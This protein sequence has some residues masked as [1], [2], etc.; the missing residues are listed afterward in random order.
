MSGITNLT[1]LLA[2][3]SP[4]LLP[5]R[6]VFVTVTDPGLIASL[7]PVGIFRENEGTTAICLVE[8]ADRA[9]LP[10]AGCYRQITM[11]VHSSL[12][13]VGFRADALDDAVGR[14]LEEIAPGN[15]R[16]VDKDGL[17]AILSGALLGVRPS[18]VGAGAA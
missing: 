17:R 9:G 18:P 12:E 14:V 8:Q 13:A 2:T 5:G 1:R 4:L 16:V 6:F 15:P 10:H 7:D 11:Q 3:A